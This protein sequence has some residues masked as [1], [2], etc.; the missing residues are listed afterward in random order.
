[1]SCEVSN[2]TRT[3]LTLSAHPWF[4]YALILLSAQLFTN[5]PWL[6]Q[7][8]FATK[9]CESKWRQYGSVWGYKIWLE[10]FIP[11]GVT[12]RAYMW[13]K[14]FVSSVAMPWRCSG[15]FP[16]FSYHNTFH[17]LSQ[18]GLKPRILG[19]SAQSQQT[20]PPHPLL[21]IQLTSVVHRES[22][23]FT[24]EVV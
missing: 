8:S 24:W 3:L 21:I 18:L 5:S 22:P 17:V 2:V 7:P 20:D 12:G 19:F 1:M 4:P 6:T 9:T 14:P 13:A 11:S 23:L 10:C 16:Y 15:T